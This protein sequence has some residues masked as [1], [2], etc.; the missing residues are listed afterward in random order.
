MVFK[1]IHQVLSFKRLVLLLVGF[2]LFVQLIVITYNHFS[3]YEILQD[4]QHFIFRLL[5]GFLLSVVMGFL[6]AYPD[7]YLIHYLNKVCPWNEKLVKRLFIE[8]PVTVVIAVFVS[9]CFTL[10]GNFINP[11]PDL[12]NVFVNNALIFSVVNIIMAILLEGWLFSIE[13][14]QAKQMAE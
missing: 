12:S 5:I 13:S 1:T 2:S 6:I 8:F 10:T 4:F 3:G 11:Y 14:K 7:L 9:A